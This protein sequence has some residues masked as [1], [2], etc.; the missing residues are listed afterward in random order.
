MLIV[1]FIIYLVDLLNIFHLIFSSNTQ[2][3]LALLF[4]LKLPYRLA[5]IFAL[6]EVTF[7]FIEWGI[8]Y[9]TIYFSFVSLHL[10][11]QGKQLWECCPFIFDETIDMSDCALVNEK[12]RVQH[13]TNLYFSKHLFYLSPPSS[14]PYFMLDFCVFWLC[15]FIFVIVGEGVELCYAWHSNLVVHVLVL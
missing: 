7:I 11:L 8:Y 6:L 13:L 9:V 14:L 3:I 10:I 2:H 5:F 1:L 4:M 12:F 15:L